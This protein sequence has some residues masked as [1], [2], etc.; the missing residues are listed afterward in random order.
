M[1]EVTLKAIEDLLDDKFDKKLEPIKK[2]LDQHTTALDTLLTERKNKGE[3]KIVLGERIDRLE[4]WGVKAGEKLEIK[5][6]L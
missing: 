3:A 4:K 5:L 2:I 6:E 1:S